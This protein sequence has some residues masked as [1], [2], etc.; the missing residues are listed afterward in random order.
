MWLPLW[1]IARLW[2]MM[3]ASSSMS[4]RP[5]SRIAFYAAPFPQGP[6]I[7]QG[8]PHQVA[9]WAENLES[10]HYPRA[11]KEVMP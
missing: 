1:L 4:R 10:R 8:R 2:E 6:E 9:G 3:V 11:D 7:Q 5:R